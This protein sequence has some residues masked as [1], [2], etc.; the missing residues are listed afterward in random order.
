MLPDVVLLEIF[1][2]YMDEEPDGKEIE[3]WHTLVH[4]CRSW[5]SVVFGSPRRLNL[6]LYCTARTPVRQTLDVW[7][8]LPIVIKVHSIDRWNNGNILAALEHND[9]ISKLAISDIP[10]S[11]T[12]NALA[13]LQQPFPA[14]TYLDFQFETESA[15]VLPASFLGGFAS[16]LQTLHLERIPFPGL[17]K[18]LL[19]ATHLVIL[20]LLRIPHSGYISP[21]AMVNALS[22]LTRLEELQIGFESPR[23]HPDRK[24]RRPPPRT[25][26]VLPVLTL[27]R[28]KG[29]SEYLEDLV[30]R[31]DVPQLDNLTTTF[32]HQLIFD[33]PQLTQF[34]SRIP[35]LEAPHEA[36]VEFSK[37][38][39]V[40]TLPQA[41]DESLELRTS[42]KQSE[43]QL[44][45]AAQVC[46]SSFTQT[47]IPT[48]EHLYIRARSGLRELDWQDD[49]ESGQW[50][51]FFHPF[52]AVKELYISSEFTPRIAPALKELAGDGVIEALPAL[53][54]LF[55][56]EPL[57][58]GRVRE[59]IGKF[60]AARLLS[61]RPI[62][63]SYLERGEDSED[64]SYETDDD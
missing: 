62:V 54:R 5:R 7:P 31:I 13:A 57:P 51:E 22:V 53:Q 49:I 64:S 59:T 41:F 45:S 26:T 47:L 23:S 56:E 42:C 19:T 24:V 35:K 58:S 1:D 30:A 9:R 3:A 20:Y 17:Q 2:F 18:L 25:R 63:V 14:L 21:E 32:F 12:E 6:Q 55:L 52:T 11:E 29:A 60:V 46:S 48:V 38:D 44:S 27:L 33:C 34:I 40:V 39:V 16:A 8:L 15:P 50:L 4:V 37:W 36:H 61:G 28:F 43:W 10:S